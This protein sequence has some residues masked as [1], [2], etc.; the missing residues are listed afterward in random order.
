M[1]I[2][3]SF[4]EGFKLSLPTV[5][6]LIIVLILIFTIR[7]ILNKKYAGTLGHQFKRQ[8]VTLMLSFIGLLAIIVVL[9][10]SDNSRGQLLGL[11]GILFSAAIALSSTTLLGNAM[12]GLMLRSIRNIR[13]GDFIQVGKHFG[14]VSEQGLFQGIMGR[15]AAP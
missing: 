2:L 4:I 11:I 12:A 10:L 6:T 5:Y 13:P 8:I 15:H 9:P 7:F 3:E 14:R 1:E